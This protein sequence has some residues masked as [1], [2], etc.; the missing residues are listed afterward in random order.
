MIAETPFDESLNG[1]GH[2]DS[3]LS[4]M[5]RKQGINID[6]I[7]NPIVH[8]G[9]MTNHEFLIK[10]EAAINSL[11]QLHRKGYKDV[12]SLQ[13]VYLRIK[14]SFFLNFLSRPALIKS[15]KWLLL[16]IPQLN[17][18][19]LDLYKLLLYNSLLSEEG[20]V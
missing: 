6:N 15:L 11:I 7:K 19:V 18:K 2:E 12:T 10:Q 3:L 16:K 8:K 20:K 1:Y 14:D 17:L 5:L 13:S 9:L 4:Y